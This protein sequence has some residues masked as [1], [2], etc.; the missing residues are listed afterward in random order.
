MILLLPR[1]TQVLSSL[2][3]VVWAGDVAAVAAT[4]ASPDSLQTVLSCAWGVSTDLWLTSGK[5]KT[6]ATDAVGTYGLYCA[7]GERVRG[8][9]SDSRDVTAEGGEAESAAAVA[10][11]EAGT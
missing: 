3:F 6:S 9:E 7:V 8:G 11:R 10:G 5:H 4:G 2:E 1:D